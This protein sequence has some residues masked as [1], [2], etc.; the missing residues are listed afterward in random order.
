MCVPHVQRA[1]KIE[2]GE[3]LVLDF[4]LAQAAFA[5]LL[6]N[7]VEVPSSE[8]SLWVVR[9]CARS[10]TW[11]TTFIA[12]IK[13]TAPHMSA[14]LACRPRASGTIRLW[15]PRDQSLTPASAAEALATVTV[16]TGFDGSA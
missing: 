5:G 15:T 3:H 16:H 13:A 8:G 11:R 6:T 2:G 14:V 7:P 1:S 12:A 9:N 10:A 4:L